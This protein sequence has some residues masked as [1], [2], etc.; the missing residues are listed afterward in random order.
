MKK[1][2]FVFL[3]TAS[4]TTLLAQSSV[5]FKTEEGAIHG[6]DPVAY[7][8]VGKPVAGSKEFSYDYNGATWHFSSKE[9]LETFK[10]NPEK[11]SPQYGGYCA[12]GASQGHKAATE[13]DAW[14]IVNDKLYFNYNK[15]VQAQWKKNQSELIKK[16]D[17]TWP[18][19]K[20]QK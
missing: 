1:A 9:N 20:N 7:F 3:F 8:K 13:V 16:A 18:T 12:F 11:Y 15:S 2:L 19:I 14:S 6:Y 5:V 4:L 17:E 10:A